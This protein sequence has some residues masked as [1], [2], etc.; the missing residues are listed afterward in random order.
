MK[1]KIINLALAAAIL[2][3]GLFSAPTPA[4]ALSAVPKPGVITEDGIAID[5]I[6][7][8]V[9]ISVKAEGASAGV[10]VYILYASKAAADPRI[11]YL[12]SSKIPPTPS[13]K[14]IKAYYSAL[15]KENWNAAFA[16]SD[17]SGSALIEIKI[18]QFIADKV[19]LNK[20][21][22][23]AFRDAEDS[24]RTAAGAVTV[25]NIDSYGYA[26]RKC[27]SIPPR[28]LSKQD[29]AEAVEGISEAKP[30]INVTSKG[31]PVIYKNSVN[32]N[33][34]VSVVNN[35]GVPVT[36]RFG[37]DSAAVINLETAGDTVEIPAEALAQ[38]LTMFVYRP[39]A[40]ENKSE[41]TAGNFA[42]KP[43]KL[44]IAAQPRAPKII[45]KK[46]V[47]T[48]GTYKAAFLSGI[49]APKPTRENAAIYKGGYQIKGSGGEG[50]WIDLWTVA[51]GTASP[52]ME[53]SDIKALLTAAGQTYITSEG[54]GANE[55]V[56][57]EIR[58][59]C[60]EKASSS[61]AARVGIPAEIWNNI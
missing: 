14:M 22:L 51:N 41:N 31:I 11:N 36:L 7:E 16:I 59:A 47:K 34:I 61:F 1:R 24:F 23:M 60:T 44:S 54:S 58:A 19:Y 15:T 53:I 5:Y 52:I 35:S 8:S 32:D 43:I 55:T 21:V 18:S 46:E 50:N 27:I 4:A 10:P 28:P 45:Y 48:A 49:K 29:E 30:K 37:L 6:N 56:F 9:K 38:K 26:S 33:T 39:A 20:P 42:G 25:S 2:L 12:D 40:L 57:F 3:T 13:E 17:D